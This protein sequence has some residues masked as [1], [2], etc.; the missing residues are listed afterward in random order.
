MHTLPVTFSNESLYVYTPVKDYRFA[1][2]G[3]GYRYVHG[4]ASPQEMIIPVITYA[5]NRA[6]RED[7]RVR[8][9]NIAIINESRIIT[10][11]AFYVK[12]YQTEPV[13][14]KV[15]PLTVRLFLWDDELKT[16][17]S[18]EK[19]LTFSSASSASEECQ[20]KVLLTLR[21]DVANKQ[22]YL[23]VFDQDSKA[24]LSEIISEPFTVTLTIHNDW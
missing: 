2:A 11:N 19:T 5:H 18:D 17:V 23:K 4:G 13:S 1:H 14:D 15:N 22:Y 10:T 8:K 6:K 9:V 21:S 7:T 16:P 24:L 3:P 20:Q 12:L